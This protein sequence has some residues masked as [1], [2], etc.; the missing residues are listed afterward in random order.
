V[1]AA[2]SDAAEAAGVTVED[3]TVTAVEPT[4][5]PDSSLGCPQPD[6]FYAQ[7]ETPGYIVTLNVAGTDVTYHTEEGEAVVPCEAGA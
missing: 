4:V 6:Q 5:W 3:V 2:V 1:Q 7:V